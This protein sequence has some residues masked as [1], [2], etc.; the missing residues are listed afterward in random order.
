MCLPNTFCPFDSAEI[1]IWHYNNC[2]CFFRSFVCVSCIFSWV[3]WA[4]C[5]FW[6]RWWFFY[7]LTAH[8]VFELVPPSFTFTS[9]L[10]H[11]MGYYFQ[12]PFQWTL[13]TWVFRKCATLMCILIHHFEDYIGHL[14][15]RKEIAIKERLLLPKSLNLNEIKCGFLRVCYMFVLEIPCDDSWLFKPLA[16]TLHA[17]ENMSM[18]LLWERHVCVCVCENKLRANNGENVNTIRQCTCYC[19]HM[20]LHDADYIS[21]SLN[22]IQCASSLPS[23]LHWVCVCVCVSFYIKSEEIDIIHFGSGSSHVCMCVRVCAV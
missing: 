4:C 23:H 6:W 17:I 22:S 21:I 1:P 11:L 16:M 18:L 20:L 2:C 3:I 8:L 12:F 9:I 15:F 14:F 19:N 10:L 5:C 13:F 7:S